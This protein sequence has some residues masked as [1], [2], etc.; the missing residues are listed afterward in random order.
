MSNKSFKSGWWSGFLMA[1]AAQG[2]HWFIT[3]ASHPG[4]STLRTVGVI[5]QIVICL[6]I[7][8]WLMQ[9]EKHTTPAPA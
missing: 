8:L 3:P 7:S 1:I 2:G 4:A 9:R 6:G 5:A